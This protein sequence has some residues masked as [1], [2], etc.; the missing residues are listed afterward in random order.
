MPSL[1]FLFGNSDRE[2]HPEVVVPLPRN[3]SS[4]TMDSNGEKKD[5]QSDDPTGSGSTSDRGSVQEKGAAGVP[6]PGKLTVESL[7]AE[8]EESVVAS[9]HGSIY[10]RMS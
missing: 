2:F 9:S 10:D 8:V 4:V 3:A 5:G 7:R 6:S 1:K